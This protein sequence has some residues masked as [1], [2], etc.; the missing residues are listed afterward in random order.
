[1]HRPPQHRL[2]AVQDAV[3][4]SILP[5]PSDLLMQGLY[6]LLLG[7]AS[8]SPESE[9]AYELFLTP[10]HRTAMDAFFLAKAPI[11]LIAKVLE[12]QPSVAA[13]YGYLFMDTSVFQNRL[14]LISYAMNYDS[15]EYGKELV[16]AA[17]T[18]GPE[19]LMWSY[20]GSVGEVDSHFIVRKTMVDSFFR[21]MAHK[22]NALT[23]GVAKEA[24]KW[25]QTAIR[26][27]EILEKLEPRT[28]QSAFD[29]LRIALDSRDETV[30]VDKP[31]VPLSEI[32]H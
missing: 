25:M 15:D 2:L 31:P 12:M 28:T 8:V 4:N 6:K 22:G 29:E 19:Y 24:Q 30:H 18:A 5:P 13:A 1:M 17:V 32:L 3:T 16:R 14:E 21:S 9:G 10:R 26:N 7:K 23:S 27:A 11:D 20:G